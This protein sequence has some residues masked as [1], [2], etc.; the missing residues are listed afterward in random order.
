MRNLFVL[1]ACAAALGIMAGCGDDACSPCAPV[2]CDQPLAQISL[3][4]GGGTSSDI[5]DTLRI[6]FRSSSADTLFDLYVTGADD[7][8]VKTISAGS[9]PLFAGAAARLSDGVDDSWMFYVRFVSVPGGG[10]SGSNE[11]NFLGGGFSGDYIPD[12]LGAEIT[13]IYLYINR[14][15]VVREDSFTD[16]EVAARIVIMGKP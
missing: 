16:Y 12:L 8:T 15:S 10:G 4:M 5:G 13:K 2:V 7:S 1:L 9:Y 14:V 3:G 6:L 11:W